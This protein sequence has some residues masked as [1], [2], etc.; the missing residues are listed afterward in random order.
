MRGELVRRGAL[1]VSIALLAW[2]PATAQAA[3]PSGFTDELVTA[4]GAPTA[5]AFTPTVGC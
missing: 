4:V 2:L 5:L 3:V 1:A